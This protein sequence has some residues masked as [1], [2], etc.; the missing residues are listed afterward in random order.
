MT[1]R[2][3]LSFGGCKSPYLHGLELNSGLL[4]FSDSG[5]WDSGILGFLDSG[6]FWIFGFGDFGIWG[7]GDLG[8]WEFCDFGFQLN[9]YEDNSQPMK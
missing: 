1:R 2:L 3:P 8:I 9:M 7:F 6:S 5:F 4:G